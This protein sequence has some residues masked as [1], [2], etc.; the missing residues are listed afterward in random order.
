MGLKT[1]RMVR[2]TYRIKE[3]MTEQLLLSNL[4]NSHTTSC[5]CHQALVILQFS[6]H[7]R[8]PKFWGYYFFR[9]SS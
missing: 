2:T 7:K 6:R 9:L 8:K 4:H 1:V 5:Y 3:M